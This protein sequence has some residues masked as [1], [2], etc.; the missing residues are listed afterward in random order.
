M[1]E[2][3][4]KYVMY[5]SDDSGING[6]V[7]GK[8]LYSGLTSKGSLTDGKTYDCIGLSFGEIRIIDDSGEA[9]YYHRR[10]SHKD[11]TAQFVVLEDD[12]PQKILISFISGDISRTPHEKELEKKYRIG[13]SKSSIGDGI[14]RSRGHIS[15]SPKVLYGFVERTPERDKYWD[16]LI[17]QFARSIAPNILKSISEFQ[18]NPK[19]FDSPVGT[20][21]TYTK[22]ENCYKVKR[23]ENCW[24]V[25]KIAKVKKE[26][27][28]SFFCTLPDN[29]T[30]VSEG[31]RKIFCVNLRYVC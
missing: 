11:N 16:G 21:F 17:K 30:N 22:G 15:K 9:F 26:E 28:V 2:E 24:E 12:S 27:I 14:S 4:I 31:V 7:I 10:P 6:Q 18:Q 1:E 25:G 8:V 23:Q 20:E 5:S 3:K 29:L 13:M 19:M